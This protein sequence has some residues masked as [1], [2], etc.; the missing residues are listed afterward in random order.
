MIILL[1]FASLPTLAIGEV[2]GSQAGR[3]MPALTRTPELMMPWKPISVASWK[4]SLVTKETFVKRSLVT[5]ETVVKRRTAPSE[6]AVCQHSTKSGEVPICD[7]GLQ[8]ASLSCAK[9][10]VFA[11]SEMSVCLSFIISYLFHFS[12][13]RLEALFE[14]FGEIREMVRKK[15]TL[16]QNLTMVN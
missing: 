9:L 2:V 1:T 5:K 12:D 16:A 11:M 7:L 13:S 15:E 8:D 6:S 14:E 3:W 4:R 10:S